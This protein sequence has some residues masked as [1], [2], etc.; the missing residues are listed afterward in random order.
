MSSQRGAS[1]AFSQGQ[2]LWLE[3]AF[4][5][6]T[7]EAIAGGVAVA[8]PDGRQTHVSEGFCELVGWSRQEL[9]GA[10]PPFVYWPPEERG[11]IQ[12][13]FD[14]TLRGQAP[15]EGFELRL[16]HRSGQR[17]DALVRIAPVR[18][19]EAVIGWLASVTDI[20]ERR[21]IENRR[22]AE[23]A[24]GRILGRARTLSEAAPEILNVIGSHL[25][26]DVGALWACGQARADEFRLLGTW[27]APDANGLVQAIAGQPAFSRSESMMGRVCQSGEAVW[28]SDPDRN[29][30]FLRAGAARQAGLRT[31]LLFPL[32]VDSEVSGI[33]EFFSREPGAPDPHLLATAA[34]LGRQ[35]GQFL[36]RERA[37]AALA[38]SEERYRT[39]VET[40]NEGVWLL[41]AD[42]RT[43]YT[44]HRMAEMLGYSEEELRGLTPLDCVFPEDIAATRAHIE[45]NIEGVSEQFD[46]RFRRKDGGELLT[47]GCTSPVRDP[48]GA[49]TGALG[50]FS[51]LTDR[52]HS[53]DAVYRLAAIVQSSDDA[54]MSK[55]LDGII[56]SCNPAAERLYGYTAE[57]L[58]GRSI[59]LLLPPDRPDEEAGILRRLQAGERV[60]HFES[61]RQRKDGRIIHVS[62]TISPILDKHGRI[63][64]ASNV[65]RDITERKLFE[66]QLRETQKLESL[67]VLAGGVAHDFNNLLVGILG[68]ASLALET[69]ATGDPARPLLEGV[70]QASERAAALTGQLLAYS[71]KGRFVLQPIDVSRLVRDIVGLIHTSIPKYVQLDLALESGLPLV[72]ADASQI[73]QLVMN[74][75]INGAEAIQTPAGIVRVKTSRERVDGEDFLKLEVADTGCG[76]D[77]ATKER[78]FDPFFTTKFTGRGLG[79]AAV[80]GIVRGHRGSIR[81][82]TAPGQGSR[83]TVLLPSVSAA[84]PAAELKT[85]AGRGT[86]TVLVIDDESIVRETARL[87]LERFGY[88]VKLAADG[89]EALEQLASFPEISLVLLDLTMPVMGGEETLR[90]LKRMRPDLRV[91]LSSG[92]NE[93]DAIQRFEGKGLAGFLQKPYTAER[94]AEKVKT[95]AA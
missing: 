44:N 11:R 16:Q 37:I 49:A 48:S 59:T 86:G 9:E 39:I 7:E 45:S 38:H 20:T 3:R 82:E 14:A 32:V 80:L 56:Q 76:M 84:A 19:G 92:Y 90:E 13:A 47:L 95:V 43:A 2:E 85:A 28:L 60:E 53:D 5:Q 26:W 91:I 89:R 63:I 65:T 70:L 52:K 67:G 21:R 29:P 22:A 4:R 17:F 61:T 83:F 55:T 75:V 12:A 57:E 74:L 79:L 46:Q 36:E 40:A 15:R 72:E 87:A 77:E 23:H 25:G 31:G 50:L 8:S 66:E 51:D 71:G 1:R 62:M 33:A 18:A 35:M 64:G 81:V 93:L 6:A 68:N 73:E 58:I 34:A 24:V 27:S 30:G 69:I 78:I 54:I 88:T 42:G 41:D 94:L 10:L